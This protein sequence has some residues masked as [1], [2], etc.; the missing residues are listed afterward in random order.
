MTT[1]DLNVSVGY[2]EV[3]MRVVRIKWVDSNMHFNELSADEIDPIV[4]LTTVGIVVKP[5]DT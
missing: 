2:R 4:E 3:K 5:V 1:T